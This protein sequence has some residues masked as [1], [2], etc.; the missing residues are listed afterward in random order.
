MPLHAYIVFFVLPYL[1]PKINGS[2]THGGT[3]IRQVW[4]TWMQRF[5]I[6]RADKQ[7]ERQ[8]PVKTR[9][10]PHPFEYSAK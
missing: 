10:P 2:K 4:L 6:Y 7:T 5:F 1:D 3:F 9:S 8:R